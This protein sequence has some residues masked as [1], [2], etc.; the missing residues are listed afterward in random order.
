ME[1]SLKEIAEFVNGS[2]SGNEKTI[3]KDAG[4]FKSAEKD[5]ITL[6]ADPKFLKKID[7]TCAL[8]IVV[9]SDF[10]CESKN[11]IKVSNPKLAFYRIVELFY[12]A[13]KSESTISSGSHIGNNFIYGKNVSIAPGA[14][15]MNNI[16]VGDNV[17]IHPNTVIEDDVTIGDDVTIF[18]NVS[19]MKDTVIGNRV[20]I[21]AGTVIGS[22][23]FGFVKDQQVYHKIPHTGIVQIDDDVEIGALNAID[24]ATFGKTL[25]KSGVKT[26]N[27]VHVA[28]N[29]TV[30]KNT[31]LVAQVGIAGSASI[32]DRVII[33]GQTGIAGHISIG[34]D[35]IIGPKTGVAQSVEKGVI[36]SGIPE[37]PHRL[38]LKTQNIIKKLP[39]M[40]K[41]I[42]EIEKSISA[43]KKQI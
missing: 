22:D 7:E 14:V 12:P 24:R 30:G 4:P 33:A 40:K 25:I 6:A 19:V 9:P 41:R 42:K 18:P 11:L 31:L 23:G 1:K 17:V 3:I 35:A 13:D 16:T 36:V 10:S 38:W 5:H 27:L 39:E 43:I 34:D 26:D 20:T 32:G 28:H 2:F 8:T 29:V 15:I 37:M 21:H